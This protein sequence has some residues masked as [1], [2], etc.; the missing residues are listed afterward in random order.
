MP[1]VFLNFRSADAGS[2]AAV[3][4][5][6]VLGMLFGS[7]QVFR[8]SRSIP[9]GARF[10]DVLLAGAGSC[11][12]MLSLIG[13]DWLS[14]S[15]AA[16][17]RLL[18]RDDDWVRREIGIALRRGIPLIPVLLTDA[19]RPRRSELPAEIGEF[20]DRQAV[21]LRH[22]HIG[23]DL[24]HLLGELV[25]VAP[26][27]AAAGM[28]A[29]ATSLPETFVPSM[30]LRP[31]YAVV[32]FAGRHAEMADLTSWSTD[33]SALAARLITGPAGQGKTRLALHLCDLMREQGWL[34]GIVSEGSGTEVFT[35]IAGIQ[36]PLLLVIDYAEARTSALTDLAT[37]LTRRPVGAVVRLL[38]LARSA[39]EWLKD[40][41]STATIGSPGSLWARQNTNSFRWPVG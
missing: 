6:E 8:S 21:Y 41:L 14:A 23:P 7:D 28:F 29:P 4:L 1:G 3:L 33:G 19:R 39:G 5:D 26:R 30:L 13:P 2:Y 34:A 31:E 27:L 37:A 32:P 35:R 36:A 10:D 12:V 17:N 25:R 9:A 22:R 18:D 24:A 40:L 20:A 15:N 38:L 11:D 16:G